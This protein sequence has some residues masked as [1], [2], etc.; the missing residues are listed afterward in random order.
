MS[1][2]SIRSVVNIRKSHDKLACLKKSIGQTFM[3]REFFF[4]KEG[5]RTVVEIFRVFSQLLFSETKH[6]TIIQSLFQEE[7]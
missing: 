2:R 7:N 5:K 4:E 1:D 6:Q 3:N